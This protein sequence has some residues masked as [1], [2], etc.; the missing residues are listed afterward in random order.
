MLMK[1]SGHGQFYTIDEVRSQYAPDSWQRK[2]FSELDAALTSQ[3]RPFPCI[4][5]VAGHQAG[6]LRYAFQEKMSAEQTAP[7]LEAYLSKARSYGANTSL[8]LFEAPRPAEALEAYH[9]RFW[10]LLRDIAAA[11]R[12]PWPEKVPVQTDAPLWE[13]CFAGE[14]VFVVCN[15]PAHIQRQS[16]RA[17][18]FM[19]TFQPRWVFD[20]ILGTE[21]AA[22]KSFSMVRARL[23]KYDFL[24]PSPSLGKYG[25]SDVREAEQYF[26]DDRNAPLSCPF[27]K[28]KD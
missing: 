24:A 6:Q 28:L 4:Y 21:K 5:G 9:E 13:F 17:S 16:R 2:I 10:N 23:E 12:Q 18:S 8:V 7:L 26:L 19:L 25:D 22:A 11:D 15:T 14:P 1:N 20:K 3:T 27:H